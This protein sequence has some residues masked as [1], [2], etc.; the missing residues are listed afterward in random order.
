MSAFP[1]SLR[2]FYLSAGDCCP[3]G[4][5][6]SSCEGRTTSALTVY[7]IHVTTDVNHFPFTTQGMWITCP[8]TTVPGGRRYTTSRV[9]CFRTSRTG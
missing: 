5:I 1:K 4:A 2:L 6:Y 9:A 8:S 3:H 7:V